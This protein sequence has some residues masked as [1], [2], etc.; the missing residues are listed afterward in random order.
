[1]EEMIVRSETRR[2]YTN[3]ALIKATK[4]ID[5]IGDKIRGNLFK[6]AATIAAVDTA[7][8]YK[9]DGFTT[10][11]EWVKDA[12]GWEKSRSHDLLKIGRDWTT[13]ITDKSGKIIGYCSDI[14][15]RYGTTQIGIMI[16]IGHETAAELHETGVINPGMTIKQLKAAI[17]KATKEDEPAEEPETE[18]ITEEPEVTDELIRVTDADGNAYDI[19]VSVLAAYRVTE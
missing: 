19:P 16:P 9:E 8:A 13:T 5:A 11:H 10:V 18:E 15:S 14:D 4:E 1:M 12:F 2:E 7:E 17:A 6:I 3:K